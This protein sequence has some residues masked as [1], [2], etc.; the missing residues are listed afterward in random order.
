MIALNSPIKPNLKKLQKYLEKVNNNGWYTNFGPLHDEL[1]DKLQEY[2]G[3]QNLLL[4]SNGT[5]ALQLAGR[6][7]RIKNLVT[8]PF[9]FVATTCAYKW[10][11]DIVSFVDIDR[12]SYN[13]CPEAVSR[14]LDQDTALDAI[15]AT[16]VYGNPCDVEAFES[17]SN[18]K[19]V[20]LIYDA[21][22]TFGVKINNQSVL[23][24][25]DASTLSFHATKVFHAVEGGAVVFKDKQHFQIAK[26]MI[27]FGIEP[28]KGIVETG[29][30][31]KLNEYQA[32]VGLVN[33]E[34]MDSVL[35]HRAELFSQYT[36]GL[37][38]VVELPEWHSKANFN[39]AYMP[40]KLKNS[41]QASKLIQ[42]LTE[43]NIQSRAYFSPA[44]DSVFTDCK[45]HGTPHS[46][47]VTD[48]ILCLPLHVDMTNKDID[49]VVN[50]I[51]GSGV[52]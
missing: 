8:T 50:K 42:K 12:K 41:Q 26:R 52:V 43:S 27:N 10:Q 45:N 11:K 17:L 31:G 21:A 33:L 30:N 47:A 48:G 24:Y 20:K 16:H 29:I 37:Q 4:V 23:N 40:I 25:G 7:L 32:A 2:L 6:A 22:H 1:T 46:D 15:V 9:S 44:L 28:G 39:G 35:Q 34:Q 13:L 5:V 49:K 14:A 38:D 36:A 19:N 51:K 18:E 3:V